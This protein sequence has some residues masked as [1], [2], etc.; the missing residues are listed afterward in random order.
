MYINTPLSAS[1]S[2]PASTVSVSDLDP[3]TYPHTPQPRDPQKNT[4][5]LG[6]VGPCSPTLPSPPLSLMSLLDQAV[7]SLCDIWPHQD[8]PSVFLISTQPSVSVALAAESL[9]SMVIQ[10]SPLRSQNPQLPSP[11]T[12]SSS[13]SPSPPTFP[14]SSSG[15]DSAPSR[16]NL[17]PIRGFVHEVLRRSRTSGT[18]LQTALCYLE[19]IR[20]K[21]P[22][23]VRREQSG[24]GSRG[25]T[26]LA[27]CILVVADTPESEKDSLLDILACTD[28]AA[29]AT[30][31]VTLE[32]PDLKTAASDLNT[33][34]LRDPQTDAGIP[35]LPSPRFHPSLLHCSAP[36]GRS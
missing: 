16:S 15:T 29:M 14:S 19:A 17:V 25:E 34:Q 12:P 32:P 35:A 9:S 11:I 23:L 36:D 1:S 33:T 6:L 26:D 28:T 10:S 24:N 22:N 4:F 20:S 30:S 18:V 8:I 31:S 27:D 2:S 7:T 21:V 13:L 5:I 3:P